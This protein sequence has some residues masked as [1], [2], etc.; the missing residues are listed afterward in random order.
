MGGISGAKEH[1]A[2]DAVFSGSFLNPPE[3][4]IGAAKSMM[5]IKG[6]LKTRNMVLSVLR[7]RYRDNGQPVRVR[8]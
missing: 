2:V 3:S 8:E 6:R 1:A 4:D 7:T 5:A